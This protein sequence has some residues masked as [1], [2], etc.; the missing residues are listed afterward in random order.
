MVE[1]YEATGYK[2]GIYGMELIR[3]AMY[4]EIGD[5]K[6]SRIV[7]ET[8]LDSINVYEPS[9]AAWRTAY[10]NSVLGFVDLE[11]GQYESIRTRLSV[12]KSLIPKVWE[13][14]KDWLSFRHDLL[15]AELL[16][17]VDSLEK[18]IDV[19]K[20]S[21]HQ[22]PELNQPAIMLSNIILPGDVLARV[23]Q[24]MGQIDNAISEYERI[25]KYDIVNGQWH[26]INPKYYYRLAQLYEKKGQHKKA[27]A[28]YRKVID[29]W[30]DTDMYLD[31][32]QN[33][34]E[35]VKLLTNKT[36]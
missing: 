28:E 29:I 5:L 22:P 32:L 2:W 25:M 7:F 3:G 11:E 12:I 6:Q 8:S 21:P 10:W 27:A 20:N 1:L 18:A 14:G 26:L 13:S 36:L 16:L 17:R 33:A 19:C 30:K 34:K 9:F 15:Y 23:Y 24:H 35:R 4:Y 31:K